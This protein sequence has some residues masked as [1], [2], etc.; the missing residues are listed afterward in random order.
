MSIR[1]SGLSSGL[2]TDSIVQALVSAYTV[3]K[4]KYEKAQTKL[5]WTQDIWSSLNSKVYSLY[6]SISDL[7]FTSAYTLKKTTVSDSTKATVTASSSAV[8][9]TQTLNILQVAQSGYLTGGQLDSGTTTS[10]TLAE[11]GYTGGDASINVDRGDGTSSTITVSSS[12][13]VADVISQLKSAGLNASLDTTNNRLFIS[14]S[15][16]G[17]DNDFNLIAADSNGLAALTALGL[18]TSLYDSDGNLTAAGASYT[19]YGTYAIADDGSVITDTDTVSDNIKSALS[20]YLTAQ[21]TYSDATTQISN[22]TSALSYAQ[23][24]SDVQDFYS[25]YGISEE[26]QAKFNAVLSLSSSAR[27]SSL[28]DADGN[29]YTAT[30]STD[31]DGNTIYGYADSEG[32]KTYISKE[33]TYTD[34]EGNT[35]KKD[36]DGNYV[37]TADDE[38]IYDGDTADLTESV[39]YYNVTENVDYQDADGNSYTINSRDVTT[40]DDDG[41]TT[42][43]TQYYFT[44]N[45]GNVYVS[46]SMTGTFTCTTTDEEGSEVTSSMEISAVYSYTA[47]DEV[48]AGVGLA[49]ASDAYDGY[50]TYLEN[51]YSL[52]EDEATSLL[53]T[54]A[55][56]LSTVTA[57]E[58][59]AASEDSDLTYSMANI[60]SQVHD[61]YSSG[62]ATGISELRA[63]YA[64][65]I[66]SLKTT[67]NEA[68]E[69]M[70]ENEA[71][72]SLASITDEDE[73]ASAISDMVTQAIEAA[74]IL[75]EESSYTAAATKIDG[76]DA[77]IKLNGVEY[78]SSSNAI[79]VNG[80]TITALAATGDGDENAITI[81]TD[82][83]TQGIYDKIK[84]FLS[85]YNS[86][87]NEICA[88]YNA[89]SA[90]GYEPLTDD[91]KEAMSETEIEKWEE[92]IKDSLLRNDSTLGSIMT[93]MTNA[94]S[95][96][97]TING[98]RYSLSSFG[99]STLGYFNSAEN[100]N[101]AYHIDGDEDD[102]NTS[103][104]TDK[105]LAAITS[106]PDTVVSFFQELTSNLY[107]A[108]GNKM[109]ATSLS[110]SFTIYNDKQMDSEYDDYTE[111]IELWEERISDKEEYYY[112]KF[113]AMETAL[114]KLQS[115]QSSLSSYLS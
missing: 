79:T 114:A 38:S 113:S 1:L 28:V 64:T 66:A 39:K 51:N 24:Y 103:G 52:S 115:T 73:L 14:S 22:L 71:V 89:D 75:T 70:E 61:T 57:Y 15:S 62:S 8:N 83:D 112:S 18:N 85:E 17:A 65:Q 43:T 74:N 101:Y 4:Q 78:T 72:S 7:R 48:D 45:D 105:L 12:S 9:G 80:L 59:S 40:T 44:D 69:T 29:V 111:L 104:N 92:K 86:I 53:S 35:Y 97:I 94:M 95:S 77:V 81:T 108:I 106:D 60:V 30:T 63:T 13:T 110:S 54:F 10:T 100:E 50:V 16:T 67:A 76:Q 55:S 3:K 6:T 37:S 5:S 49:S 93:A 58:T 2:D 96:S 68:S 47:G 91:E 11:L 36:S 109:S 27:S 102:S 34:T 32:N 56:N 26:D 90:S 31:T 25:N 107:S 87:I 98:S 21:S 20:A 41:N 23:A 19:K 88:L 46:D 82:T 33:V 84:E 99:I 42:T